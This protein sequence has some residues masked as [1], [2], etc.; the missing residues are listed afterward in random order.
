MSDPACIHCGQPIE[1][2]TSGF[3]DTDRGPIH[4]DCALRRRVLEQLGWRPLV[5]QALPLLEHAVRMAEAEPDAKHPLSVA[6]ATLRAVLE[7]R[8]PAHRE[9][10]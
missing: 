5:R 7:G 6:L 9:G 8:E 4:F 1:G 2:Y 3:N 10:P